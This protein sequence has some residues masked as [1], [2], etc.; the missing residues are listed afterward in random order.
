M[1]VLN[2]INPI[3]ERSLLYGDRAI[4]EVLVSPEETGKNNVMGVYIPRLMFGIPVSKGP[5]EEKVS[6][7]DSKIKNSKNKSIGGT[8]FT[9]KNYVTLNVAQVG[10]VTSP[11]FVKGENV[12]V[13]TCDQDLKNMFILPFTLGEQTR[14]KYDQ[15][16][17][18][19]P[20]FKEY[21]EAED[22]NLDNTYG[23]QIDTKEKIVSIWT[24]VEGDGTGD[25]TTSE[26]EK[27]KYIF[28]IFPKEGL[29]KLTDS[30]KRTLTIKTDD[31]SIN[32]ENEA[33]S[34]FK[35]VGD[36]IS[37]HAKTINIDGEDTINT[38]GSKLN[39][40][41]TDITSKADTDDEDTKQLTI[42]GDSLDSDYK[43][44]AIKS[45][46]HTNT[47]K[48]W[49]TDSPKSGFSGTC[50]SKDFYFG[51]MSPAEMD[52]SGPYISSSGMFMSGKPSASSM[53]VATAPQLIACLMQIAAK[54][55]AVASCVG[56]PPTA[57]AAVSAAAPNF[58][59]KNT[60]A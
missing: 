24:S 47:T 57:V 23:I 52:P 28:T 34:Y 20:N 7:S 53:P 31:D 32:M 29:V 19:I 40:E 48:K 60:F 41:H 51:V 1:R 15:Y 8:S 21:D 44:T 59:S 35:M 14:R 45:N 37:M 42:H 55:D 12:F 58:T 4:G 49:V 46:E 13:Q 56:V 39:R 18:M 10:N 36:T 38:T 5:F 17:L 26:V 3:S 30:E 43:T 33:G 50:T 6:F 54:A 27:G 11:K 9:R 25:G 22:L 16:N 2:Y